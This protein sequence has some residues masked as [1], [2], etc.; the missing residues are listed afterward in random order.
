MRAAAYPFSF[1]PSNG[2]QV[3]MRC[4][5]GLIMI[6]CIT[7]CSFWEGRVGP[8]VFHVPPMVEHRGLQLNLVPLKPAIRPLECICYPFIIRQEIDNARGLGAE[9]GEMFWTRLVADRIFGAMPYADS[10]WPGVASACRHARSRGLDLVAMGEITRFM[11]GGHTG[12]TTVALTFK[13]YDAESQTLIWSIAHAGLVE[14][15]GDRDYMVFTSKTRMPN[16][17]EYL[18]LETLAGDIAAFL[19][20]WTTDPYWEVPG[21]LR[22]VSRPSQLSNPPEDNATLTEPKD[23]HPSGDTP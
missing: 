21:S 19:K 2:E 16:S 15:S 7:G 1:Y 8:Q 3:M 12:T 20:A 23:A 18:V 22:K 14:G 10:F 5:A 13:L 4:M 17:P 11:Q 6:V 9:L